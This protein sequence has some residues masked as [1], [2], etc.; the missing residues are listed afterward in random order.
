MPALFSKA[1]H[2]SNAKLGQGVGKLRLGVFGETLWKCTNAAS[3][4]QAGDAP[5]QACMLG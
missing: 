4:V 3:T 1:W 5:K 2:G